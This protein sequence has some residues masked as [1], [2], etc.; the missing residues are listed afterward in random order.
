MLATAMLRPKIRPAPTDQPASDE[1]HDA[2]HGHQQDLANR[3]GKRN[4]PHRQQVRRREMQADAE[5]QQ[6]HAHLRKLRRK[7]NIREEARGE[8][9]DQHAGNQIA[10]KRRQPQPVGAIAK[11]GGKD[12]TDRDRRYEG[13]I[14][15][16]IRLPS[17]WR[18]RFR[19]E[20]NGSASRLAPLSARSS[21]DSIHLSGG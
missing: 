2:K 7:R 21:P 1:K 18:T 19:A 14:L 16:H 8:G 11:H 6:H 15:M 12:E 13:E 4:A 10:D 9:S 20:V 3:T 17:M 5:H